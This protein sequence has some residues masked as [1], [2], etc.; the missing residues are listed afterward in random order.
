MKFFSLRIL[1]ENTKDDYSLMIQSL[2]VAFSIAGD[3]SEMSDLMS[4]F[5]ELAEQG[6]DP[7]QISA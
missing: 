4:L 1:S 7:R 6:I 5:L 3:V 2:G